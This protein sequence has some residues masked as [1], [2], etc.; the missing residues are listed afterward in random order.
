MKQEQVNNT[1]NALLK[2]RE[3]SLLQK[4]KDDPKETK[5]LNAIISAR[6]HAKLQAVFRRYGMKLSEG[7]RIGLNI[8]AAALPVLARGGEIVFREEDGSERTYMFP[9]FT[10]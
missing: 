10:P 6:Q 3:P 2:E 9:F 4:E 7:M 1:M 8:F 5:R